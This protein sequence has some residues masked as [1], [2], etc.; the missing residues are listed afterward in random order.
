MTT[1]QYIKKYK[2]DLAEYAN[3]FNTDLFLQDLFEELKERMAK[4]EAYRKTLHQEF[5][6]R[7]FQRIIMELQQKF[8]AISNKK[9]GGPLRRELW[10]AFYAKYI[11]PAR[12]EI[13]PKEHEEIRIKRVMAQ[14]DK[15]KEEIKNKMIEDMGE[16]FHDIKANGG[17]VYK[18]LLAKLEREAREKAEFE[19]PV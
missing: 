9:A 12:A 8:M 11:I 3:H 14:R 7:M 4:E 19:I 15:L 13:F 1:K 6:F 16:K 18:D 2:L 10:N 17:P 5:E